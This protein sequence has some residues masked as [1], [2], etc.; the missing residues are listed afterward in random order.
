M[1]AHKALA[2]YKMGRHLYRQCATSMFDILGLVSPQVEE[3]DVFE[4]IP[5]YSP[6]GQVPILLAAIRYLAAGADV[7]KARHLIDEVK[8]IED[9]IFAESLDDV[10]GVWPVPGVSRRANRRANMT[11]RSNKRDVDQNARGI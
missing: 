5:F 1:Q 8:R 6:K 3:H 9:S 4:V 2:L 11:N 10:M 7:A